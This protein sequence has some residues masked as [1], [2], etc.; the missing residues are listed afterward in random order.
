MIIIFFRKYDLI[1]YIIHF[2]GKKQK[3]G[4]QKFNITCY[5]NVTLLLLCLNVSTGVLN[6]S[7]FMRRV[8]DW[9]SLPYYL[10][11]IT[12]HSL[13]NRESLQLASLFSH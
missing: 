12:R 10:K 9:N 3:F 2:F 1:N 13:F 8:A 6:R 5:N 4:H 11:L 7:F